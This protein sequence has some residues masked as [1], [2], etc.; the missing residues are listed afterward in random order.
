M[1]LNTTEEGEINDLAGEEVV[2][3]DIDYAKVKINVIKPKKR[4]A[5]ETGPERSSD[6]ELRSQFSTVRNRKKQRNIQTRA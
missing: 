6:E 3:E 1:E 5:G 4:V 2:M